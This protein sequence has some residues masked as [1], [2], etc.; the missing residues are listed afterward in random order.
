MGY[1]VFISYKHS[2]MDGKSATRDYT[3]ASE[4]HNALT[5]A[6]VKTF[7]S[8]KD[9]STGDFI[10]EIYDAL[11]EADIM[12]VVGT[13]PEH[14]RSEWVKAEWSTFIAEINGRRKPKGDVYTYLEGMTVNE[15]P[16]M[17]YKWQSYTT[18]EKER[19]VN[20]IITQLGIKKTFS[21]DTTSNS[22]DVTSKTF[23][24][25]VP[26]AEP[27]PVSTS[28][29]KNQY[30]FDMSL[31][32]TI[33]LNDNGIPVIR[34]KRFMERLAQIILVV[35]IG[36]AIVGGIWAI[37]HFTGNLSSSSLSNSSENVKPL[38]ELSSVSVGDHFTFGNYKES[39]FGII[40]QPIE[41]RVLA[42]EDGRALVIS[43]KLLDSKR[44]NIRY[45]GLSDTWETCTLR[46]WMND[47]FL[48]EAFNPS[49]QSKIATVTNENPDNPEYGTDGGNATQDK[50]FAL[51]VEEA[52]KYF[53]NDNDRMAAPTS[54]AK[55]RGSLVSDDD[56]LPTGEKT[57]FWWLRS[58]GKFGLRI[59][60]NAVTVST[61]GSIHLYGAHLSNDDA[62]VRP[63]LWLNLE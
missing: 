7:F 35:V 17:L 48:N 13:K 4:L 63:A 55:M 18:R 59:G 54:Y 6:G 39:I 49:E 29:T 42:V 8:E 37:S 15:L 52:E 41:W 23:Q 33:S 25:P 46:E 32:T 53:L 38:S 24:P 1:K 10:N 57:G 12:I 45:T 36:M 40:K 26:K 31:G 58:P 9:L 20:R 44:Y 34:Q 3:I 27:K 14:I 60:E 5:R 51:S 50:V 30:P 47:D 11:E 28:H 16:S 56:S 61:D 2:T 19:L 22:S 62:S 43:E 21:S